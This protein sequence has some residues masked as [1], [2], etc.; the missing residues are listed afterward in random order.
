MPLSF[1]AS[2]WLGMPSFR[3]CSVGPPR[4][5]IHGL[6]RLTRHP[7]RVAHCA[8][9]PLGLSRGR[10]PRKRPRRPD[11]RPVYRSCALT[12]WERACPRRRPDSRPIS[13]GCSRTLWERA[14]P[15]RR[16]DSRPD[17]GSARNPTVGASLL[18]MDVNDDAGGMDAHGVLERRR[19]DSR[20]VYGSARN[21][22]VGASLLAMD[23]NDDAGGMDARGVLETMASRLAPTGFSG[24]FEPRAAFQ[25]TLFTT[26]SKQS[27]HSHKTFRLSVGST[28][29]SLSSSLPIQRPG[30]Q[31]RQ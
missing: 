7:C 2:L 18:A 8:E 3:S 12:L 17:S 13:H 6:T 22:T 23:V 1:G 20:P 24:V 29:P 28:I 26:H 15:R 21:P 11:S 16:P 31:A 30:L 4:P 9:P 19:P 5:A 27:D 14:C 10:K 25:S